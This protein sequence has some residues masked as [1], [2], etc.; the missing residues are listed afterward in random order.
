MKILV[1]SDLHIDFHK[2][3]GASLFDSLAPADVLI[4]AGDL[5]EHLIVEHG[6][7][8]ACAKY[9]KVIYVLGNHEYFGSDF[10][11]VSCLMI[12]LEKTL[13]NLRWLENKRIEIDGQGFIGGT[14]WFE[15]T[16]HSDY[17]SDKMSDFAQIKNLNLAAYNKHEE[18]KLFIKNNVKIGDIIITHHLPSYKCVDEQYKMDA[19]NIYF[20]SHMD[21]VVEDSGAKIWANGHTHSSYDFNIGQTRMLCNPFG[22]A[23]Q[24]NPD[25]KENLIIEV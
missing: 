1:V 13:S 15:R 22:Y 12:G 19:M 7:R 16:T 11:Y 9:N 23:H 14:L 8:L 21:K 5:G 3:S 2:D 10:K 18:T 6:L 4:I 17:F 25:F 20:A 24:P